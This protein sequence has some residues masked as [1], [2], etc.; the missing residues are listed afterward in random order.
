MN[1]KNHLSIL[2]LIGLLILLYS[3]ENKIAKPIP[4]K[5]PEISHGKYDKYL[6]QL[7]KAYSSNDNSAV[8]YTHLTLPTKA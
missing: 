5:H 8:S 4:E 2:L 1:L 6:S 3:C 7:K